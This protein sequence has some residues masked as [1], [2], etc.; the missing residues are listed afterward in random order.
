MFS[1][2][3]MMSMPPE[4]SVMRG[5]EVRVATIAAHVVEAEDLHQ[6]RD[7]RHEPEQQDGEPVDARADPELERCRSTTRP[8]S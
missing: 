8:M 4:N 2:M 5:E 6:E 3:S 1:A 7:E